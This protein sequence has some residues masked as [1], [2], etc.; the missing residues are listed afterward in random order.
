VVLVL[1]RIAAPIFLF[2][3]AFDYGGALW[4]QLALWSDM[5]SAGS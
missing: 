3:T 1:L 4:T 2:L 5:R